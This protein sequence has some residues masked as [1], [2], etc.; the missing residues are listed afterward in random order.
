MISRVFQIIL[1][2]LALAL[3]QC[4]LDWQTENEVA[5]NNVADPVLYHPRMIY[6]E[7]SYWTNSDDETEPPSR[8]NDAL[9]A[10]PHDYGFKAALGYMAL[11]AA[12]LN[13]FIIP[14][15]IQCELVRHLHR[16]RRHDIHQALV[17]LQVQQNQRR[18]QLGRLQGAG[19]PTSKS[20]SGIFWIRRK[21]AWLR[22]CKEPIEPPPTASTS[23]PEHK[24]VSFVG[25][26]SDICYQ[27]ET[28]TEPP[29]NDDMVDNKHST[30]IPEA[31]DEPS[32]SENGQGID[33]D[34]IECTTS[35]APDA[36]TVNWGTHATRWL[37]SVCCLSMFTGSASTNTAGVAMV[38]DD[39]RM[40]IGRD[41]PIEPPSTASTSRPEH[42]DVS[43]VGQ[44]S[45]ICYQHETVTE[46]PS[47]DD[48]VDNKHSTIIP[49]A[50][51]EPSNS[52]NGQGI[53][54]DSIECTTSPAPDAST[55]NWGTHATRWLS[56]VCCLSMFT[57]SASTNTA[58]VAM[59]N[60]DDR[61][62]WVRDSYAEGRRRAMA[63]DLSDETLARLHAH[64]KRMEECAAK[65]AKEV[66]LLMKKVTAS[67]GG[68]AT[69][70]AQLAQQLLENATT[71]KQYL[72]EVTIQGKKV[73]P[74]RAYQEQ[75][76]ATTPPS[77][78][79]LT[80]EFLLCTDHDE[81]LVEM[82]AGRPPA[83]PDALHHPAPAHP[84]GADQAPDSAGPAANPKKPNFAFFALKSKG[85]SSAW[86]INSSSRGKHT[87]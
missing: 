67:S 40:E 76:F 23:R 39:E 75:P 46:P 61:L 34:S 5:D 62:G 85:R 38:N 63:L 9:F 52:E 53:D 6:G 4:E 41:E 74:V 72:Q 2:F 3:V 78:S 51:D 14:F 87:A 43:F 1:I 70:S 49:E 79:T 73:T 36:S 26:E 69:E 32:N 65:M 15:I 42:K 45:D 55:V 60:D 12:P 20:T 80:P 66:G 11:A 59:V 22:R 50:T 58:G 10:N 27:H 13:V 71:E 44:E 33:G 81:T 37:S 86:A 21:L 48:M 16:R 30:I 47:N 56:S 25:H 57:G 24:D 64:G 83:R 8:Y 7:N 77:V 29:S 84:H 54:G 68:L 18:D 31:T 28:V 82:P 17:A 19:S 35:P